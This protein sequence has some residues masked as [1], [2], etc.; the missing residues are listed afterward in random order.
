MN[1]VVDGT[2]ARAQSRGESHKRTAGLQGLIYIFRRRAPLGL[3]PATL[4]LERTSRVLGSGEDFTRL[5]GIKY[6]NLIICKSY[7][8]WLFNLYTFAQIYR[9]YPEISRGLIPPAVG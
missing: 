2:Q 4:V 5:V 1:V 3:Y 7:V 6:V 9:R 8:K